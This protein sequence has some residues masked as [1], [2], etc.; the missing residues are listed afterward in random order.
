[1]PTELPGPQSVKK[2]LEKFDGKEIS[3]HYGMMYFQFLCHVNSVL[4]SVAVN[5]AVKFYVGVRKT[6]TCFYN[7]EIRYC[8]CG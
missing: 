6:K 2:S 8:L 1:M 7:A 4:C 3:V 5:C